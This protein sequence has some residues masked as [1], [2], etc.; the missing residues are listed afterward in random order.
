MSP[1]LDRKSSIGSEGSLFTKPSLSAA[2]HL[3]HTI[4][5]NYFIN[6]NYQVNTFSNFFPQP[7]KGNSN[8]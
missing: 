2:R 3:S 8:G 5:N 6:N 1:L 4:I 7:G